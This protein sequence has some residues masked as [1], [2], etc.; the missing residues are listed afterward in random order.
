[1]PGRK[2]KP[3]TIRKA[4]GGRGHSRPLTDDLRLPSAGPRP[5]DYLSP[6]QRKIWFEVLV[7]IPAGV[8]AKVDSGVLETYVISLDQLR[9]VTPMVTRTG[10]LVN[11]PQGPIRNPLLVVQNAA[12]RDV[13]SAGSELGLSPA[14]R[15]RLANVDAGDQDTMARLL[16][17][18]E[19]DGPYAAPVTRQ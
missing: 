13:R 8:I 15:T 11:S 9:N 6:S 5:P 10:F 12:K 18:F 1:M 3:S 4:E 17:L 7:E 16:D 19:Q 14:A 2:R